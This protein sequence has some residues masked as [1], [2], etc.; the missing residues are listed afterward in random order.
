MYINFRPFPFARN[1]LRRVSFRETTMQSWLRRFNSFISFQA[2]LYRCSIA[3]TARK[4][5]TN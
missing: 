1:F 3:S 2:T 5:R 4:V